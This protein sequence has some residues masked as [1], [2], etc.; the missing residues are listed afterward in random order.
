MLSGFL[1]LGLA[2]AWKRHGFGPASFGLGI[3]GALLALGGLTPRLGRYV[4]LAIYLPA[5]L[6]GFAI[7]S[8][9]LVL[10]WAAVFVPLGLLLRVRGQ[11]PLRLRRDA[12]RSLWVEHPPPAERSAYYRPF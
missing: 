2:A 8:M 11:D 10:I 1:A 12:D 3:A 5:S 6:V 9:L 4:Y 7:S